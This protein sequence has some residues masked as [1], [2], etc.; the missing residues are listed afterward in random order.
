MKLIPVWFREAGHDHFFSY[1][2][3]FTICIFS[4]HV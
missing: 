2:Y 1:A 3:R 4:Y